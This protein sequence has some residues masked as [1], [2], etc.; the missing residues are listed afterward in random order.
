MIIAM[1]A[2]AVDGVKK[3]CHAYGM[4]HFISKPF[5]PEHFVKEVCARLK[6]TNTDPDEVII[7][8][9]LGLKMMGGNK[10]LYQQVIQVFLEENKSVIEL[11]DKALL[12]HDYQMV[13]DVSHKIK[14]SAGSIGAESVHKLA[15]KLQEAAENS[16][17]EDLELIKEHFVTHFKQLIKTLKK[18]HS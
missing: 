6:R 7:N 4:E 9:S 15:S 3:K 5:D 17:F 10:K 12:N 11:L 2:D 14:G 1:T 13:I 16:Q 8:Y 18:D